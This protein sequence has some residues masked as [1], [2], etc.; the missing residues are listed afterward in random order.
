MV[1]SI[2]TTFTI[3]LCYFLAVWLTPWY[4]KNRSPYNLKNVLITYNIMMIL[5]NLF[6]IKEV[7]SIN[8]YVIMVGID[9]W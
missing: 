2:S 1:N 4:M 7:K 6:I 5:V 9:C 8:N 3:T